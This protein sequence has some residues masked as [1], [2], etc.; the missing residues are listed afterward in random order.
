MP[1]RTLVAALAFTPLAACARTPINH[2]LLR[3]H[4]ERNCRVQSA[5]APAYAIGDDATTTRKI[6][7]ARCL[8][9]AGFAIPEPARPIREA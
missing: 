2:D 7:Y 9:T 3:R 8:R 5:L 4:A 6:A 1:T